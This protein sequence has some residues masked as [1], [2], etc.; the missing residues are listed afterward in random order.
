M[1]TEVADALKPNQYGTI[2]LS[3]DHV[4]QLYA[5]VQSQ[6]GKDELSTTAEGVLLYPVVGEHLDETAM[7]QGHRY[8]FLTVDLGSSTTAIR[9]TLMSVPRNAGAQV[10]VRAASLSIRSSSSST[11]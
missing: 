2:K 5:Y 3:R 1:E 11:L 6:H 4:F 10:I 9:D 7:I 8:R